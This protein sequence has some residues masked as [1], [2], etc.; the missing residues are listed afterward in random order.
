MTAAERSFLF[1]ALPFLIVTSVSA[2]AQ[3]QMENLGRGVVAMRQ[4][5]DS[6]FIGWRILGTDP[7]NIAFNLYRVAGND[8]SKPVK[9]NGKPITQGT[10]FIDTK[11]Y[12]TQTNSWYVKAVISGKETESS[13]TFSLAADAPVRQYLSIPLQTPAGYTPNDASAVD[14]D[15]DGEYD[16]VLHQSGRGR[17]NPSVGF[18][19]PP[20]FQAYT[21]NGTL[22]WTINLGKNIREE[23]IIRNI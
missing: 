12:F 4:S 5:R 21:L 8:K 7:E 18:T 10:N 9:L 13:K 2:V 3:R 20:V 23:R 16:I 11:A 1:I 14:L 17:D 15:G 22:L 19:D 6:V